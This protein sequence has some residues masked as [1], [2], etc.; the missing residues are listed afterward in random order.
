MDRPDAGD[1]RVLERVKARVREVLARCPCLRAFDEA[2]MERAFKEVYPFFHGD[3][4]YRL[5]RR[6]EFGLGVPVTTQDVNILD[7]IQKFPM[8]EYLKVQEEWAREYGISVRYNIGDRV[9]FVHEQQTKTG[10][11]KAVNHILAK[12]VILV[13][14]TD[15]T[16]QPIL[17]VEEIWPDKSRRKK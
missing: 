7:V 13:D 17:D 15:G 1:V 3:D 10:T 8:E 14:G 6:L 4:G 11:V 2:A 5:A 16:R 9:S 12:V